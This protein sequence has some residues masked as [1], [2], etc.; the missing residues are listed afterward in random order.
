M[1]CPGCA[2]AFDHCG[3]GRN[4]DSRN[5]LAKPEEQSAGK[6]D[7]GSQAQRPIRAGAPACRSRPPASRPPTS[8][9]N[10]GACSTSTFNNDT[11]PRDDAKAAIERRGGK[12]SGSVSRKTDLVVAG[13]DA[14][15][16]LKKAAE[17][18]AAGVG[19]AFGVLQR[20]VVAVAQV[21]AQ[22]IPGLRR[23]QYHQHRA[24]A[25]SNK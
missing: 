15:T 10:W 24:Y 17:L 18:G 5:S 19:G 23:Q 22:R 20:I 14:G 4:A 2:I 9:P 7:G 16:K 6:S 8:T 21:L 11:T 3:R 1:G 25:H 12:V 13:E